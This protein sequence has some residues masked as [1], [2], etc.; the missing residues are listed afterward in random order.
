MEKTAATPAQI[1]WMPNIESSRW[2][3]LAELAN[4][5]IPVPYGFEVKPRCPESMIRAAYGELKTRE[6]TH[7]VA[8]RGPQHSVIEVIGSDRLVHT[9]NAVWAQDPEAGILV[10]A[11]VNSTW[12]GKAWCEDKNFRIHASAGLLCLDP[13]IYLMGPAG[14]CLKQT[15]FPKP[16]KVFRGVDGTTKRMEI[17]GERVSL[18][19][20]YLA[21]IGELARRAGGEITWSVDDRGLWLIS[22][23]LDGSTAETQSSGEA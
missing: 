14:D 20:E 13:D 19:T 3:R 21:A 16:R 7:F 9:I 22:L 17:H 4:C 6:H 10:Q 11:M 12:C 23:R 2:R 15:M 8:V 18:D 1:Q 5:E